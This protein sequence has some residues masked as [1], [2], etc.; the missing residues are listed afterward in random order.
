[1]MDPTCDLVASSATAGIA[2]RR[3]L[4]LGGPVPR[5]TRAHRKRLFHYHYLVP[6]REAIQ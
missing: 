2:R 1:M 6:Q 3:Q 5:V 4:L